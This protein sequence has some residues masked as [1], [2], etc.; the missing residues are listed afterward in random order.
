MKKST[1]LSALL[2]GL[3]A[4]S[5]VIAGQLAASGTITP[6]Q[7]TKLSSDV[8]A[9]IS[10]NV[11]A[12]YACGGNSIYAGACSTAGQTKTRSLPCGIVS[13]ATG[14][15]PTTYTGTCTSNTGSYTVTGP[16]LFSGSSSGGQITQSP[17]SSSGGGTCNAASVETVLNANP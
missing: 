17:I 11:E 1:Y 9:T 4:A 10:K 7:C 12:A 16:S 15:T 3:M 8:T 2:L 14:G 6:V 13:N 5:N